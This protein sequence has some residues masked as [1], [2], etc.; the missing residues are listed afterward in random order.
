MQWHGRYLWAR[1]GAS[2]VRSDA[3]PARRLSIVA[4]CYNEHAGLAEFYRRT[5]AA[6]MAVAASDYEFVLLN[7][8]SVDGTWALMAELAHRDPRVV[9][10]ICRVVM[11]INSRSL[12]DSKSAAANVSSPSTPTCRIRRRSSPRCGG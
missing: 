2:P 9:P 4:P 8:G 5:T 1:E 3:R 7:D 6:A 10:S 12:P 11:G